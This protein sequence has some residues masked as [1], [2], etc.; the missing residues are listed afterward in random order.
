M[1]P[2]VCA[3]ISD[4]I[5]EGRLTATPDCARQCVGGDDALAGSG[6][7]FVEVAHEGNRTASEE[8]AS[9]VGAIVD[10]LV[11]RPYTNAKGET[12]AITLA[13]MLFVTPYNAQIVKL[14]TRLGDAA[15]IGTVDKFQGQEAPIVF[16]SMATSSAEEAPRGLKFLYSV[17]RLNVAVS[18][19][20]AIA[21]VVCSPAV[22]WPPCRTPEQMRL[23]NA[24][25]AAVER[26]AKV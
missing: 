20:Q 5:Y 13:D 10:R 24:L 23:V 1:H 12:R 19:A 7:R 14:R 26:A 25:C 17:N 3:F 9:A 22:R 2:D 6:L 8:E 15:K 21:I 4:V 11:G 18:R 16:Y